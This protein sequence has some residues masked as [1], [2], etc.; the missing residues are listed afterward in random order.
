MKV[1]LTKHL[2]NEYEE[3][4]LVADSIHVRKEL[5]KKYKVDEITLEEMQ[6]TLKKLQKEAHGKGLY[7][8]NDF[9]KKTGVD[10]EFAM[11]KQKLKNISNLYK[12]LNKKVPKKQEVFARKKI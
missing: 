6:V 4:G 8:R 2:M 12:N 7:T 9:Y 3:K 11:E 10:L 1:Y 5:I